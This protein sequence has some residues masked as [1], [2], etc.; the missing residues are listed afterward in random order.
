MKRTITET[1]DAAVRN[2]FPGEAVLPP[3]FLEKPRNKDHGDY[4]T[5]IAMTL[6]SQLKKNPREIAAMIIDQLGKDGAVFKNVGIAGPGFIN[7]SL[8]DEYWRNMLIDINKRGKAYGQGALGR[9]ETVNIEFVS[10]NPT[11]PLHVGHGRGAAVGDALARVMA[12]AGYSVTREYYVNDAGSQIRNLGISVNYRIREAKDPG[13]VKEVEFP[14]SGYHGE[15]IKE[16]AAKLIADS[17]NGPLISE[18]MGLSHED[19]LDPGHELTSKT[20]DLAQ[21]LLL[22]RISDTLKDFGGINFDIWSS[23]QGLHAEGKVGDTI[24][25]FR[26]KGLIYDKDG[27]SW[28]RSSDFGD[29]KDRVVVKDDGTLTYLAADIAYHKE[30]LE[31]KYDHIIDVWGADHHGYIPRVRGAIEAMGFDPEKFKVLLVQ[32]VS[33][34]REGKPVVMS[35]RSGNFVT[36]K[37]VVDEV[38]SDAARY[39]FLMRRYDSHFEFDLDL[40]KKATSDNPVFYVQYMHARICSI[41]RNAAE[42]GIEPPAPEDVALELLREKE[43]L[44]IIKILVSFP[45]IVEGS[46]SAMEPHRIAF[47]LQDLAIAFHSY[48]NKTRVLVDDLRLSKARLYLVCAA[49]IIV[50]NALGLLGVKAPEKM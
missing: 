50:S 42:E 27:A 31:K 32:M 28:F 38:G 48:Y 21:S 34:T 1:L 17:G 37:E 43:E 36:L 2:I 19:C 39:F 40:A 33:L 14:E 25:E 35:K 41:I 29:E 10:A 26:N 44:E 23:E 3:V 7:M 4:A 20:G 11:G 15:Y 49:K 13:L 9:G 16:V 24:E 22:G 6:A 46:A 5:N 30:K 45:E 8:S 12:A 47:F 18:I